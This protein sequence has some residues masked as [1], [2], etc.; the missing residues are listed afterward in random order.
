[1]VH[2][3]VRCLTDKNLKEKLQWILER[4]NYLWSWLQ[5]QLFKK[6]WT[7]QEYAWLN[8][9]PH[10]WKGRKSSI[11]FRNDIVQRLFIQKLNYEQTWKWVLSWEE[12]NNHWPEI[13]KYEESSRRTKKRKMPNYVTLE[14]A[15]SFFQWD[16]IQETKVSWVVYLN[17]RKNVNRGWSWIPMFW[18]D[19][20]KGIFWWEFAHWFRW[21]S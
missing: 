12:S 8:I 14:K 1:M 2:C 7:L 11:Q 18:F 6:C 10:L 17:Q 19:R 4:A 15:F 3:K 21:V 5:V 20:W 13:H 16:E 9:V